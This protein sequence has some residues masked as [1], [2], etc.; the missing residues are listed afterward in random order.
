MKVPWYYSFALFTDLTMVW[1]TSGERPYMHLLS[2]KV[3]SLQ[4]AANSVA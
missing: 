2:T 3:V 4:R 1:T